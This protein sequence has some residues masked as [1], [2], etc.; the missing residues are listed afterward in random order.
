MDA[1][2]DALLRNSTW[3]L[4]PAPPSANLIDSHWVF[5]VKHHPDG[6]VERF[7]ACI[8]AKGFKQ[9]HGIDYDDTFSPVV[10][11]ATIQVLLSLAVTQGWHMRQIDIDN[12]FLHG[13]L[14]EEVY[15][16]QSPS[17]VDRQHPHHVV[18][19]W[20][21]ASTTCMVLIR[22]KRIYFLE[23]FCYCFSS[24]LCVLNTTNTD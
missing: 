11:L 5:K 24:N 14:E 1:E 9:H 17:F 15:M 21:E 12:A 8:I 7:K 18:A 3:R 19:L 2:L 13:Y 20:V 22:P 6:S 4:V 10:K 16:V 23:H